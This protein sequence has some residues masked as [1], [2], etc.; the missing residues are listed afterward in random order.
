MAQSNVL[1]RNGG[2]AAEKGAKEDPDTQG[3]DHC[4]S[5]R[6]GMK[7]WPKFYIRLL[8]VEFL[9]GTGELFY[10]GKGRGDF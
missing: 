2:G 10:L 9:T 7:G 6:C 3:E 8:N 4:G 5:R 1:E